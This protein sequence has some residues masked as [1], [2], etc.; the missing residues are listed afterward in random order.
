[1]SAIR[2]WAQ[3]VFH[4]RERQIVID[5]NIYAALAI[6]TRQTLTY[7]RGLEGFPIQTGNLQHSVGVNRR[8]SASRQRLSSLPASGDAVNVAELVKKRAAGYTILLPVG[9]EYARHL[10]PRLQVDNV[11]SFARVHLEQNFQ[12]GMANAVRELAA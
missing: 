11:L 6:A 5:R 2:S 10:E 12:K 9:M 8:I 1:M 4:A 3:Y 7:W